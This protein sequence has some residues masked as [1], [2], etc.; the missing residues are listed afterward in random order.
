MLARTFGA[1]GERALYKLHTIP[2]RNHRPLRVAILN[3]RPR[4][5]TSNSLDELRFLRKYFRISPKSSTLARFFM[6]RMIV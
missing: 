5:R 3:S 2:F 1:R 6:N 4:A